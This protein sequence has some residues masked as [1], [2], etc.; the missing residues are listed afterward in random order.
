MLLHE[1]DSSANDLYAPFVSI[2]VHA[3]MFFVVDSPVFLELSEVLLFGT[4][5]RNSCPRRGSP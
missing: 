5:M 4:T 1:L 3:A 2:L